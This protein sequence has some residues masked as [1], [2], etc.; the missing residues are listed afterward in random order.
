[1]KKFRFWISILLVAAFIAS[2]AA[3]PAS[4]LKTEKTE[5]LAER[6]EENLLSPEVMQVESGRMI[7][8]QAASQ[9]AEANGLFRAQFEGNSVEGTAE[10][11]DGKYR[12]KA[13][14]TDGEAWHIKLESNYP[15][16][17]GDDYRITYTFTSDTAGRVKLGD[18]REYPIRVGRNEVTGT[19]SA[20]SGLT[21]LDLQLGMLSPFVIDFEKITVA[22]MTDTATF[23][24]ILPGAISYASEQSVYDAH[25]DGY[26]QSLTRT[27]DGV[28][29]TV[30]A[31]PAGA[32]VWKSKLFIRTGAVPEAG[33][34]YRV[35]AD[36]TSDQ[37]LDFE[38]CFNNDDVEKGYAALY[39]Q[40][41]SAGTATFSQ[42]FSVP[43]T[44]FTAKEVVLQP[45]FGKNPAGSKVMVNSVQVEEIKD[46]YREL[47]PSDF[48]LDKVVTTGVTTQNVP[49]SYK[50][51]PLENFTFDG[52]D[53]VFTGHDTGYVIETDEQA[54]GVDMRIVKAP[55]NANDRGVWKA[56]LYV[57]T[58]VVPEAGQTYRV[59]FDLTP[60][61]DQAKYEI[62]FDGNAENAY[63][64]LYN[65]SL[66]AGSADHVSYTFTP[67]ESNGK[68]VLRLQLGE[69]ND[70]SGNAYAFRNLK[71]E[72]MSGSAVSVLP[73]SFSYQTGSNVREEHADGYEQQAS[74]SGSTV[75]LDISAV[76]GGE[77]WQSKLFLDTGVTLEEGS[78][79]LVSVDAS[80]TTEM[81]F[82]I[83]YNRGSAEK[84][85]GA[86]YGQTLSPSAQTYASTI[87]AAQSGNLV[88]QF[89]LGAS[90]AGNTVTVSNVKVQKVTI[91]SYTEAPVTVS[92]YSQS[93]NVTESH[94][95]G[96]LAL[97]ESD[98]GT[99]VYRILR[100]PETRNVWNAKLF[101]STGVTPEA[102]KTYQITIGLNAANGQ[103]FE[104]CYNGNNEKDYGALYGQILTSG[105]NQITHT[106][107][108]EEAKGELTI[109]VQLGA[110]AG[111]TVSVTELKVQTQ[112][113]GEFN[114]IPVSVNYYSSS[115]NVT[116]SHDDGYMALLES[117]GGKPTYRILRTPETHN[118]WNAKLYIK[119]GFTPEAGNTYHLD[120]DLDAATGQTYE[121]CFNGNAEKDYGALYGQT[122]TVGSNRI[123]YSFT[124]EESKGELT[125]CLQLGATDG[126]TVSV[127]GLQMSTVTLGDYSAVPVSVTYYSSSGDVTESHDD[128]YTAL[129]ESQ[130]GKPTYR[131]LRT[132][133]TH[134]V[135]NAKL[136]IKTGFTPEAG[137]TYRVQLDL[138]AANSQTYEV[139]FNGNAE[140]DYGALYGQTLA[141]G[142][143][144][145]TYT[146]PCDE[147][148]GELTI[149]L[150]LGATEGNTVSVGTL[151]IQTVETTYSW[152]NVLGT[153]VYPYVTEDQ[154]SHTVTVDAAYENVSASLS[155]SEG[156]GDGYEQTLSGMTLNV[157]AVPEDQLVWKSRV[158][159]DTHTN[160]E[161][162][163]KYLVKATVSAEQG[164][165]FEVCYSNGDEEKGYGAEYSLSVSNNGSVN[166]NH[167]IDVP[168][169]ITD[170][171]NL[172]LIFQFGSTPAENTISISNVTLQKWVPEH[173]ENVTETIQT[174]HKGS[175]DLW[176]DSGYT[177]VLSGEGGACVTFTESPASSVW[178]TKL[179][180]N[181]GVTLEAGKT[182]RISS[183]IAAS[184]GYEICYNDG[185]TEKGVLSDQSAAQ[186]GLSGSQKVDYT[187]TPDHDANLVIQYSIGNAPTGA[188]FTVSGIKVEVQSDTPTEQTADVQSGIPA[189]SSHSSFSY[190]AADGYTAGIGGNSGTAKLLVGSVPGGQEVW[191]LKLFAGTGV[192]LE[193]G[194]PYKI[195]LKVSPSA[196][197]SYEVCFNDGDTEKGVGAVYGL[198][199]EQTVVYEVTPDADKNLVIQVSAGNAPAGSVVSV[200]NITVEAC[201]E[202]QT[203]V[204]CDTPSF[205]SVSSFSYWAADGYAAGIGGDSSTVKLL[206]GSV[207]SGQE[208]W[209]LKLF[210]GTGVALEADKTYRISMSVQPS[211]AF[212]YEVCFND[213][214]TEKGVGALYEL[215]GAQSIVYDVTPDADKNLVIQISAGNAPADST[216][217][218][219]GI[220]VE[221]WSDSGNTSLIDVPCNAPFFSTESSFSFW[222]ADGYTA[223]L[224]GGE[225]GATLLVGSVPDG[226]EV[227]K[228]KLFTGALA[229][230]E[231]NKPYRISLNIQPSATFNYEVC[232]NDGDTEKGVG[233]LYDQSGEQ[234][235]VY[236]VTPDA[237]KNLVIQI[238]AGNAPAGSTVSISG[239][240]LETAEGTPGENLCTTGFTAWSPVNFWAHEDYAATASNTDSSAS[241]MIS[242]V[243]DNK[244]AWKVKLFVETGAALETG[245]TYQ[246]RM[247]VSADA[248]TG[249]EVCYNNGASEAAL[250]GEYNLT[251]EA[252]VTHTVTPEADA[253]LILQCNLGNANAGTTVTISDVEV[254][255]IS[256]DTATNVLPDSIRFDS[257]GYIKNF[258]DTGY[259]TEL[260]Q[261][262]DSATLYI[263][264]APSERHP[265]NV[266]LQVQTGFTPEKSKGYR[267][268][269]DLE[270]AKPQGT[271][272]VFYDGST[273]A[274]YGQL[275]GKSLAKG[276][277]TV[278]YIINPGQSKGELILQ[279]RVGQTNGTD[280]NTY[281]VRNIKIEE[282]AYELREVEHTSATV[283][284]FTHETYQ[285]NLEKAPKEAK[286]RIV[287]APETGAEAWKVKLFVTTGTKLKAEQKYRIRID[288]KAEQETGYEVCFNNGGEEKGL[289]AMYGLNA[290]PET[291]TVE[292]AVYAARDTDL[293][294]QL[295]LGNCAAPNTITISDVRVEK[296][297]AM[298]ILSETEYTFR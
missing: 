7:Q 9:T 51:I 13:T 12:V 220:K 256:S 106:F 205:S 36:V 279:L 154:E 52:T 132:P 87:A 219:S 62:C 37:D 229:T 8:A 238:S 11:V 80:A 40:H 81:S 193:A 57:D 289:G 6:A 119:T 212:N 258:A 16:T 176:S 92:Y 139:C 129:L 178:Q 96:Y 274:A 85:Y 45:M 209:K 69:T 146:F 244:E 249:F 33:K 188:T 65:R 153:F 208:V 251:T 171:G 186:Y 116:E 211:A 243:P 248:E 160:L 15:T 133:E 72:A 95:E 138:D 284:A 200:S 83:D 31:V 25:D 294:L 260:Q 187:V 148:K 117:Q 34:R 47:L 147:V 161:P 111:N 79:Y 233:A 175:F 223:G 82:E 41:L 214:D 201:T 234:T 27:E 42:T 64:A 198:S 56:R 126:N 54:D 166:V 108:C 101:I 272:E 76:G 134:N 159:V 156:H 145:V 93:G 263:H 152:S 297:G 17:P 191:K 199:G 262:T 295:S 266:K 277:Q 94:D 197:F 105:A 113:Q 163:V 253:T 273:E 97:L 182:Y 203:P 18:F 120:L 150:Q 77:V 196:A 162:G 194:K 246:I 149:C 241:L 216:V 259:V 98:G 46:Q 35:S 282:V 115:G 112:A 78:R 287:K 109:C 206:V 100:T 50:E 207:P 142:A 250:G 230:L 240:K 128:G 231:A 21:Y 70:A 20:L 165:G 215:S 252:T 26:M 121:V 127:S 53:T 130:G 235:I 228:L 245:K 135:W 192:T 265:W 2:C 264:S 124:P 155:A 23:T 125:I 226:Q 44:G 55:E 227:W 103:E 28:T 288:V 1:M 213:G 102:G 4:R 225:N 49:K 123:S 190:W 73:E 281:T 275:T 202:E 298:T 29:M 110:T 170:A 99:P 71:V 114:E 254:E 293:V 224:T 179:F 180:A 136:N 237:D 291:R 91:E 267:V 10:V 286:M 195:S 67:A 232:F 268:S 168:E 68:L 169:S 283:T 74:A 174:L 43:V 181:T 177:T 140:K 104:V 247:K 144:H 48:A 257:Q 3:S 30:N 242:S 222:G 88:L 39:G 24:S 204:S 38:I 143:N 172:V 131:I 75:T 107:A 236:D 290:Y 261:N 292:Y 89:D 66:T 218:V 32:E 63:G 210:A 60:D 255:E 157:S 184:F 183:T 185:G 217:T 5:M 122:L 221:A 22:D 239:I 271:F 278:S 167:T 158:F 14:R 280:G 90:P 173:E 189:F 59:S 270:A 137:K 269:F 141:A 285:T 118:V 61:A 151:T 86:L 276:N 58:G 19:V 164:F 84:G 296:A